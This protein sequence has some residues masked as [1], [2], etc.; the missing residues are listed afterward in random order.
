MKNI[1]STTEGTWVELVTVELT[2]T[3]KTLLLSKKA[4]DEQAIVELIAEIKTK[5]EKALSTAE[6]ETAQTIYTS[7]K[8]SLT[9]EDVYQLIAIDMSLDGEKGTGILNCRVNGEHLQIRF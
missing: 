5:R 9:E 2:E 6:S 1:Q 8:P 7:V 3:E 4:E